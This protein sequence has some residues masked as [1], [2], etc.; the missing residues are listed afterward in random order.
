[1]RQHVMLPTWSGHPYLMLPESV[2]WYWEEPDHVVER[3]EGTWQTYSIHVIMSGKGFLEYGG[4]VHTLQRGDAF[5]Y[6]PNREQKYYSSREEPW[7]V[8][9]VHFYGPELH[10]FLTERGF[11][12]SP[13]WTLKQ[14]KPWEEA[15][16]E[17]MQ[18]CLA[19][20]FTHVTRLSGLVYWVLAE[21][22][23]QSIP[24]TAS[25]SAEALERIHQILPLM[26]RRA[27]EPFILEEWAAEAQ[28]SPYYFCKL[29]KKATQMTPSTFMTTCRM[30]MAKQ[31]L[32]EKADW[33][34]SRVA[35]QAGYATISYFHRKF[36]EH[37]GMTPL[38]FRTLFWN[39]LG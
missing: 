9:W 24:L 38:E 32:L 2:G 34:V 21:F 15:H 17:L 27:A 39:R 26:R 29:F 36:Q 35:E 6:Y 13:L 37:E 28:V 3:P 8:R 14:V 22:I 25:K 12:V 1:M 4:K 16:E 20:N 10:A 23:N 30:Q 5:L 11:H 31:L 33:P 7:S 18:E 19:H